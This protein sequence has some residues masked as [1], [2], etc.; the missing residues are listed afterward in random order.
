MAFSSL[1]WVYYYFLQDW[2]SVLVPHY[3]DLVILLAFANTLLLIGS[4]YSGLGECRCPLGW[5]LLLANVYVD[6]R[7]VFGLFVNL[8]YLNALKQILTFNLLW[9]GSISLKIEDSNTSSPSMHSLCFACCPYLPFTT[10]CFMYKHNCRP[11]CTLLSL[12]FSFLF[13]SSSTGDIPMFVCSMERYCRIIL[14]TRVSISPSFLFFNESLMDST[15]HSTW[16][17]VAR[18]HGAE[19]MCFMPLLVINFSKSE[20]V[21]KEALSVTHWSSK[22]YSAKLWRNFWIVALEVTI[23]SMHLQWSG[24]FSLHRVPYNLKEYK[25]LVSVGITRGAMG[26]LQAFCNSLDTLNNFEHRFSCLYEFLAITHSF[27]QLPS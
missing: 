27:G 24:T 2:E 6:G 10:I 16:L 9:L 5:L 17:F 1:T 7:H 19:V 13:I 11:R 12:E 8:T 25:T 20:L 18:Q 23:W 26:S 21:K 15:A 3:G 22:L 14:H 4:P